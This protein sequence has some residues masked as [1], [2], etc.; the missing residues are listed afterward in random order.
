[1]LVLYYQTVA[2]RRPAR[3]FI[4]GLSKR[5]AGQV[6]A[7]L[8]MIAEYGMCAP[9]SMKPIKGQHGMF[10]LR[11]G[12]NRVYYT[13]VDADTMVILGG[14]KKG[15]QDREIEACAA[16]MKDLKARLK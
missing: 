2:G 15:D 1:L 8:D 6:V 9:V 10:E 4:D 12:P 11:I 5:E 3:D 7:D 13:L 16:R 14:S